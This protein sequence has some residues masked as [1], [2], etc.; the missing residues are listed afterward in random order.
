MHNSTTKILNNN[1]IKCFNGRDLNYEGGTL[2]L[3]QLSLTRILALSLFKPAFFGHQLTVSMVLSR[4]LT[5]KVP[6]SL[7]QRV[8]TYKTI[9]ND[10]RISNITKDYIVKTTRSLK[11]E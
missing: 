9:L 2:T 3:Q 10:H 5:E 6:S 1:S 11:A 7:N 8:K 4:A